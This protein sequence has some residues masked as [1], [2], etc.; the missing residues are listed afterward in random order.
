MKLGYNNFVNKPKLILIYGFAGCGKTTLAK[1]L[2][3]DMPFSLL[4][5]ADGILNLIGQWIKDEDKARGYVHS[6]SKSMTSTHLKSG[7]DVIVPMLLLDP[8][9]AEELNL[10]ANQENAELVELYIHL[11]KEDAIRYLY[12]RG[13]WGES[14]SIKITEADR[15]HIDQIY[16]K[17]IEA[18]KSRQHVKQITYFRGN[19]DLTH[20][21]LQVLVSKQ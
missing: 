7:L 12:E 19:I 3:S 1:K 4:V 21:E 20:K 2:N 6:L 9:H 18:M 17:M 15:A 10:I 16:D 8:V 11:E 13:T 5:E 14:T